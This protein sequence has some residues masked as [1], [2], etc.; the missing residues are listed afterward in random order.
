MKSIYS[1]RRLN[2]INQIGLVGLVIIVL[3]ALLLAGCESLDTVAQIGTAVGVATGTIDQSQAA[4]IQK[5]AKAVARS[6]Q[7]FTPE[8]EYYIGRTVGAVIVNKYKPYHNL[9]ATRY[10]N[11][12]GQTL[13]RASDLPETFGGYHF[14]VLDSDEINA[15]ATSGGFIFITRGLLRCCRDE[16]AV[17]AVLAHEIGHVQ[18]RHGLQAIKKS[19]VTAALTTLAVEGTK[20]FSGQD[21]ADLVGTFEGSITD[22]TTTLINNGYSREFEQQADQAAV[23]I[24]Q[25]VGYDPNGLVE[26]LKIMQDR[27]RPGGSDFAKTHPSPVSRMADIQKSIGPYRT[28]ANSGARQQRFSESLGGI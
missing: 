19:R 5:S 4:S 17:A 28:V 8:Q 14:L 9:A 21:L 10:V 27:L 15:F 2:A 23:T 25:R 11:L 1:S 7:D 20:T 18:S 24:L 26:M 16:D 13:A 6:F 12:L 3:T 22:I